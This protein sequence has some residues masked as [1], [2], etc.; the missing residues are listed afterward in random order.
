MARFK[1][2]E[3]ELDLEAT[4]APTID[5]NKLEVVGHDPEWKVWYPDPSNI[6]TPV[7]VYDRDGKMT[8]YVLCQIA[9]NKLVD[10]HTKFKSLK[11]AKEHAEFISPGCEI[12]VIHTKPRKKKEKQ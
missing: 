12:K 6:S 2:K 5:L 11:A 9:T 3:E 8:G 4:Q 10:C 7:P 1:P